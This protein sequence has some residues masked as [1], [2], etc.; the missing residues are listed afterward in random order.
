M[1]QLVRITSVKCPHYFNVYKPLKYVNKMNFGIPEHVLRWYLIKYIFWIGY[2]LKRLYFVFFS[3]DVPE[4]CQANP[5][6]V[7]PDPDNCAQYFN[8]SD[9]AIR[10]SINGA[11]N[12]PENYRKECQYPDLFDPVHKECQTFT[13]VN[14]SKR[15]EPQAPCK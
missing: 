11:V 7:L 4:Y 13:A 12:L 10:G 8:C 2:C 5:S 1:F 3:V 15:N 6:D 9:P 14:C